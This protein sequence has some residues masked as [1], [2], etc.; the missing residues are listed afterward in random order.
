MLDE[1]CIVTYVTCMS[2][3]VVMKMMDTLKVTPCT[4]NSMVDAA[5]L[6]DRLYPYNLMLRGQLIGFQLTDRENFQLWVLAIYDVFPG[7]KNKLCFVNVTMCQKNCGFNW[8][9]VMQS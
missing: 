4:P 1:C 8:I 6:E 5:N 7:K 3:C 2:C 9:D